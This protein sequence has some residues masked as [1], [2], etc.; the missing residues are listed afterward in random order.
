MLDAIILDFPG[1]P[2]DRLR[3]ALRRLDEALDAQRAALGAWRGEL[4]EL[5]A[6]TDGL[7]GSLASFRDGLDTLAVA[8]RD[9]DA[10]ARRLE[11]TAATMEAMQR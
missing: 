2:E 4:D 6:A 1:R 3:I 5:A 11:R 10:E 7:E 8:V 9:A